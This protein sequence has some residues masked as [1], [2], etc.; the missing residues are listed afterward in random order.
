MKPYYEKNGHIIYHGDCLEVLSS[1]EKKSIDLIW[2]DPPYGNDNGSGDWA[3]SRVG[4]KGAR[5]APLER[6]SNDSEKA[7]KSILP[8]FLSLSTP[9]LKPQSAFCCSISGG[10]G[11]PPRFA[12]LAQMMDAEMRFFQAVVWDKSAR[13]NGLG[14]RYRRNYEFIMVGHPKS[15]KLGWADEE[16]AV[17]NI[18]RIAP[19]PNQLHPT[20]K[21]PSLIAQF[22]HWHTHKGDLVVDPFMGSGSTI[23][24]ARDLGRKSIGI[25]IDEKYCEIAADRLRQEVLF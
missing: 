19:E 9:L 13:G 6:I 15:G 8:R 21:P 10:G 5:K 7:W 14:W 22:I 11:S 2:T 25:E 16:V 24:A 20:Q 17:P 18:T 1:L 23:V 12:Q 4:V 3:E